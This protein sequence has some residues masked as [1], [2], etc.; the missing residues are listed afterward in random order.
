MRLII[1]NVVII[2]VLLAPA[3]GDCSGW[4]RIYFTAPGKWGVASQSVNPEAGLVSAVGKAKTYFYG[5][6]YEISSPRVVEALV[7]ARKRGVEVKLVAEHDTMRKEKG[8]GRRFMKGMEEAGIEIMTDPSRRRGLMHNKFAVI[9]GTCLWTG[10]Y[11]ATVNDAVKNN[12]S[13]ILI[14]S[15]PLA[16]IYRKEF[17]EMFEEGI[18]GN[19]KEPGP[20]GDFRTSYHVIIEDTDINAYFSPEDN[21]ERIIL[22]RLQKAKHSIYFMAFSFTSAGIGEMMIDKYKAGVEVRGIFERRG[23]N[24][25]HSQFV[26]MKLEGVPVK[27]D[28][29]R[30][31]MHHKVIIIDGIR[32]IM[33]S[34]NFSRNANR[35]NDENI[36]I[37]DNAAIAAEYMA[38]FKRLW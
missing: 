27:L 1:Y 10:S 33:G 6:F 32:V 11:N 13:A 3:G 25:G 19:R 9:D 36:L 5:A 15:Q 26:K 4:W 23:A 21:I 12:N 30:N 7:A 18:F 14:Y 16:E 8:K 38:E 37:I 17:I 28:H 24:T 20:F 2:L 29:N 31:A 22:K 35:A 34:Y